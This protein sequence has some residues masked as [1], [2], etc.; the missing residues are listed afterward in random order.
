[1]SKLAA[2]MVL[3]VGLVL[4][5]A[6]AC[7]V[8]NI[9]PFLLPTPLAVAQ[10]A[11]DRWEP[12]TQAMG[13]TFKAAAAGL[14]ASLLLGTLWAAL[15]SQSAWLRQ[16]TFP[17]AVVLQTV[18]IVAIAPLV[19]LWFGYGFR[20]ILVIAIVMG[21][22]PVVVQVTA[23]MLAVDPALTDLFRLHGATRWQHFAKL[24]FPA[25]IPSLMTAAKTSAGLSTIGVVVGEFFAGSGGGRGLGGL[26]QRWENNPAPLIAATVATTLVGLLLFAGVSLV[27]HQILPRWGW[28]R[29]QR[30]K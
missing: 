4:T 17:L 22:F 24:Q 2:P 29:S 13:Y 1:M 21:I 10:A 15:L 12:L 14:A 5:W 16:G 20:S 25:A 19:L 3:L 6:T 30:P 8:L 18:P 27:E 7:K 26:I 9:S 23:G 28:R 11:A